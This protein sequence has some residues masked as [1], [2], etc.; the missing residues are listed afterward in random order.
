MFNVLIVDDDQAT[1][2]SLGDHLKKVSDLFTP[3]YIH[4]RAEAIELLRDHD[5]S[6][7]ITDV[8]MGRESDDSALLNFFKKNHPDTPLVIVTDCKDQ[9]KIELL[10]SKVDHIFL[11]PIRIEKLVEVVTTIFNE[12]ISTGSLQGI[13]VSAFLQ[14]LALDEM[15]CLVEVFR[16]PDDRGLL[17]INKGQLH[18]AVYGDYQTKEAAYRLI[19]MDQARF[20]IKALPKKKVPRRIETELMSIITEV[21]HNG[22]KISSDKEQSNDLDQ[23]ENLT[24]VVPNQSEDEEQI[25][26][27][28]EAISPS[29]KK[30]KNA[31]TLENSLE[32][33]RKIKGYKAGA[34]MNFTGEIL[35]SDSVDEQ[36]DLDNVGAVF[37]D[38]FRSSHEAAISVGLEACN[39]LAIK[40]P[41]GLIVM[42]CS[43]VDA[44]V[45][46]H[47][48]AVL[49][50]DGNQALAKLQLER[51]IPEVMETLS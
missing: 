14:L 27:A 28:G 3:F 47:L 42:L 19:G 33:L 38:I 7:L 26:Q 49:D 30:E 10:R 45:H 31:M 34:L 4:S 37:N 46:F 5:I 48:I 43:G 24:E 25:E 22:S 16:S 20:Q 2:A 11:K 51:M 29:Q 23:G 9:D 6:L 39:E 44:E 17:Y 36:V 21:L 1:L 35:A 12:D 15:S 8:E 40:T 13:P 18:D 50:S 41:N 32:N